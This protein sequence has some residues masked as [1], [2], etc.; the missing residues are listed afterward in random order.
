MVEVR[1][2]KVGVGS[3]KVGGSKLLLSGLA[4]LI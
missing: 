1:T 3:S 2:F 4:Y